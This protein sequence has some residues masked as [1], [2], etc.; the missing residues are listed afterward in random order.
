MEASR[1]ITSQ[2]GGGG[3]VVLLSGDAWHGKAYGG[4]AAPEARTAPE[5]PLVP[6]ARRQATLGNAVAACVRL[7]VGVLAVYW[8]DQSVHV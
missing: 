5:R 7:L 2:E 1:T 6:T 8:V 4:L 3:V